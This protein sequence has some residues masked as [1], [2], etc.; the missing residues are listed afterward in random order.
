MRL[1]IYLEH[2]KLFKIEIM[3]KYLLYFLLISI[4]FTACKKDKTAAE[5]GN[6]DERLNAV[7]TG[8]QTQLASAQFG[9]KGYLLTDSKVTATF[10]F[11]FTDKNRV[12]MSADYAP[13]AKESSYR[14]KAL[15]RPTLLFDTYSTLH[16]IA[17]PNPNVIG[18][19]VGDGYNS[20]FEFAFLS[21]ST[22]TVKLEG[23]FNKSKLILV[24]SKSAA[25]NTTAFSAVDDM[26][27]LLSKLRTYFKRTTIGGIEGEVKLDPA[28]RVFGFNYLDG[29]TLK[30]VS[31][32][33]FVSGTSIILYD[34]LVIGK[35]SL[36]TINGVSYD[37][38]T[39]FINASAS[40]GTA[41]QI[42][43]AI[44][45]LSYD[46]TVAARFLANPIHSTY[47]ENYNGFTVDGVADAYKVK[48]IPNF[49]SIDYYH[50]ITGQAYGAVRF[51]LGTAYGAYGPAITP[52][53]SADGKISYTLAGS[54]G[55]APGAIA[56]I[57]NNVTNN[58]IKAGGF[59]VIQTGTKVYDLVAVADARSWITFQ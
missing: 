48:T 43:E 40:G 20:D 32:N 11:S 28:N 56:P 52:T 41:L 3:K 9:W 47:S 13:A 7:L 44:T 10:L 50:K 55:N 33:Y 38:S 49:G 53:V 26:T 35:T 57:I 8:Y 34:P 37:A 39:G 19:D 2:Y 30:T 4:A 18:G 36:T 16:L 22:D 1:H 42:K 51:W 15:Q 17:D 59:Y 14:L 27:A 31:S 23:T 29:T 5:L 45:P 58:F 12:T 24:R 21:A 25:D 6:P 46:Q 54:Y